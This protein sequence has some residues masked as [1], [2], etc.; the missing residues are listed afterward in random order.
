M[1]TVL[2]DKIGPK[3]T[4]FQVN[5][6]RNANFS[7]RSDLDALSGRKVNV[8]LKLRVQPLMYSI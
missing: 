5:G 7:S 4:K 8:H 3:C 1:N 6:I 2:F